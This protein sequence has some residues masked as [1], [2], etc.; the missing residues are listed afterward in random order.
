MPRHLRRHIAGGASPWRCTAASSPWRICCGVCRRTSLRR[1]CRD[2][3]PAACQRY[4]GIAGDILPEIYCGIFPVGISG[5]VYLRRCVSVEIYRGIVFAETHR[6]VISAET[7]PRYVSAEMIQPYVS[8]KTMPRHPRTPRPW[9]TAFSCTSPHPWT[10]TSSCTPRPCCRLL[11]SSSCRARVSHSTSNCS[12]AYL[13]RFE[14]RRSTRA[15]FAS[16]GR[17]HATGGR[18]RSRPVVAAKIASTEVCALVWVSWCSSV[19]YFD[20]LV[21]V[22]G[23]R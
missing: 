2:I 3:F 15:A 13:L 11:S 6:G 22:A 9:T 14:P 12:G 8:A 10:T 16:D 17:A 23:L 18:G 19:L 5:G 1:R 20:V 4:C 7:M 21:R